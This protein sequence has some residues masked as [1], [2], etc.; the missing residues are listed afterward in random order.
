MWK[1][2]ALLLATAI[3][4]ITVLFWVFIA[5]R[6]AIA[7]ALSIGVGIAAWAYT[8]KSKKSDTVEKRDVST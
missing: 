4:A 5:P 7:Y 8:Q 2:K 3:V 6:H 1:W